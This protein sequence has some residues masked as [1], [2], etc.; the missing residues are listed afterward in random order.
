MSKE[1]SFEES[2]KRLE[3]IVKILENGKCSLDESVKLFEEGIAL[4]QSCRKQLDNAELKIKELL[5]NGDEVN[6]KFDPVQD[7]I[8]EE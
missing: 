5:S 3:E 1:L 7:S 8:C 6:A 2:M 4:S